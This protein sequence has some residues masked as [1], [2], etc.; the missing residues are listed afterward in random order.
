M[1]TGLVETTGILRRRAGRPVARAFIETSL[2]PLVLGES[3][4]VNGACLTVDRILDAGFEADLSSETLAKTSLGGLRLGAR[5][6]LER[7]TPLGGRMGGHMVL[8][9][10]DCVGHVS[11]LQAFGDA[12]RFEVRA[13]SE[14]AR[15][16]APKGSV[17]LDGVSLTLNAVSDPSGSSVTFDVMLVPHTIDKTVLRALPPGAPLNIEV[18]VLARYVARQLDLGTLPMNSKAGAAGVSSGEEHAPTRHDAAEKEGRNAA[19]DA[20]LLA[21]LRTGGYL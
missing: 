18:D 19:E 17:A 20:R 16:L 8:G 11:A 4:N 3:V 9:H 1:F 12:T 10:V 15:F 7:A 2:G 6:H 14:I 5:V 13:P 21:K